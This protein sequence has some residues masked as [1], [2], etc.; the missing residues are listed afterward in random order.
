HAFAGV[1]AVLFVDRNAEP[2]GDKTDDLIAGQRR[3]ALGKLDRAVVNAFDDDAVRR[4]DFADIDGRDGF[5][6]GVVG[7]EAVVFVLELGQDAGHLQAAVADCGVHFLHRVAVVALGQR[8]E[9]F[10]LLVG[11][12]AHQVAAHLALKRVLAF[13]DVFFPAFFFEPVADLVLGFAGFDDV[14]PI[15]GRAAVFG[16]GNDLDNF[17]GD[18]LVVDRHNAVVDLGADHP[19]ADGR[20]DRISEIDDGRAGRQVDDVAARGEGK[21]LLGQKVGLD[22]AEQV[23]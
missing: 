21:D 4:M 22:I 8:R 23:G 9:E 2:A 5:G 7:L 16:A 17:A 15:A 19:V 3:A 6:L 12:H 13:G 20:V 11:R 1:G 10:L 14:E 18:D